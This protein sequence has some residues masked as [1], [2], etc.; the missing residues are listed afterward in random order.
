MLNEQLLRQ[1]I[2]KLRDTKPVKRKQQKTYLSRADRQEVM[3]LAAIAGKL[4]ELIAGWEEHGRPGAIL[5]AAKIAR[6]W[7]YSAIE[8]YTAGVDQASIDRLMREV[9]RAEIVVREGR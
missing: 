5:R 4:D 7:V 1:R 8:H 9:G 3:V 6:Y 2:E